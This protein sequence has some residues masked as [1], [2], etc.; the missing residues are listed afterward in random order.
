MLPVNHSDNL[1]EERTAKTSEAARGEAGKIR[2]EKK[3]CEK[4]RLA[5]ATGKKKSNL[6]P[7][8]VRAVNPYT[9][10]T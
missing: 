2:K 6:P 4:E 8:A 1:K 10:A 5:N 9:M 3:E 7:G